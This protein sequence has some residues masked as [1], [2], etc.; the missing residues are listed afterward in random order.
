MNRVFQNGL[1]LFRM[2]DDDGMVNALSDAAY[3]L[4]L[5]RTLL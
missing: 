4:I 5:G 2:N 3:Y 1:Q